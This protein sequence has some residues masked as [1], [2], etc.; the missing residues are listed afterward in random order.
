MITARSGYLAGARQKAAA[1]ALHHGGNLLRIR[2]KAV[3]I[4]YAMRRDDKGL[5][6]TGLGARLDRVCVKGV[7]PRL[8]VRDRRVVDKGDNRHA[9]RPRAFEHD[10]LT[11][12]HD[13]PGS[14]RVATA[15]AAA[16]HEIMH[17]PAVRNC[18]DQRRA[19]AQRLHS[20]A[21]LTGATA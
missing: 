19:R 7:R 3:R 10:H 12:R 8:D 9:Q 13:A 14:D 17:H 15:G 4:V 1:E 6:G 5:A 20:V 16:R 11:L 2:M 18:L 21:P